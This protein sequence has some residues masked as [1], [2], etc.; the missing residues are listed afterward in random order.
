MKSCPNCGAQLPDDASFCVYCMRELTEKEAV[1]T[2][3]SRRRKKRVRIVCLILAGTLLFAAGTA[4]GLLLGGA[5]AKEP[6]PAV[7]AT[8]GTAVLTETP[9]ADTAEETETLVP[10]PLEPDPDDPRTKVYA[11]VEWFR[12]SAGCYDPPFG[13]DENAWEPWNMTMDWATDTWACYSC[14]GVFRNERPRIYFKLDGTEVLVVLNA[15][16]IDEQIH[17]SEVL[18]HLSQFIYTR[19]AQGTLED[20]KKLYDFVSGIDPAGGMDLSST[21]IR[22]NVADY[23]ILERLHIGQDEY[24]EEVTDLSKCSCSYQTTSFPDFGEDNRFFRFSRVR[25]RGGE[26]L[27]DVFYYFTFGGDNVP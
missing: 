14:P 10:G 16:C 2:L 13:Y 18:Y 11:N 15:V 21:P 3:A 17:D 4:T 22:M 20:Q 1:R 6:E 9:T 19:A 5:P 12:G 27:D 24:K 23:S 7:T 8:T 25:Y 26:Y